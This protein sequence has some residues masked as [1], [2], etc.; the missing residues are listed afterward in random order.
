MGQKMGIFFS[1]DRPNF[2]LS[3]L[4]FYGADDLVIHKSLWITVENLWITVENLD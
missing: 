1:G 4:I 2:L 3:S